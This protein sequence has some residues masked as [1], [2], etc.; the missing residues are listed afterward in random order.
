[1]FRQLLLVAAGVLVTIA[2]GIGFEWWGNTAD[3]GGYLAAAFLAV[4]VALFVTPWDRPLVV[5]RRRAP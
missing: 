2:M 5:V 3:F 1:M 4:I